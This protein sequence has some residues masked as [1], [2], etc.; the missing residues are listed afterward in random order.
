MLKKPVEER[1]TTEMAIHIAP[2][3]LSTAFARE[4]GLKKDDIN[5]LCK[6][7]EYKMTKDGLTVFRYGE[8]GDTFFIVVA[9]AVSVWVPMTNSSIKGPL[10]K[11]KAQ[12]KRNPARAADGNSPK[13]DFKFPLSLVKNGIEEASDDSDLCSSSSED[14]GG[15]SVDLTSEEEEG[16]G[17]GLSM[18]QSWQQMKVKPIEWCNFD[19]FCKYVDEANN[20]R[21]VAV[22]NEVRQHNW[23]TFKREKALETVFEVEKYIVRNKEPQPGAASTAVGKG[24]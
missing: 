6:T 4:R 1:G 17:R 13:V 3:L 5:E 19:D 11:F 2:F 14:D 7:L 22:A 12:I 18:D 8:P 23:L 24:T 21:T 10:A 20:R 15:V 9:G 16:R